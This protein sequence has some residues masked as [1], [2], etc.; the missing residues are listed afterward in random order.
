[1]GALYCNTGTL[2]QLMHA[3]KWVVRCLLLI[4]RGKACWAVVVLPNPCQAWQDAIILAARQMS[5]FTIPCTMPCTGWLLMQLDPTLLFACTIA[6]R[7]LTCQLCDMERS[8]CPAERSR[9]VGALCLVWQQQPVAMCAVHQVPA[10]SSSISSFVLDQS[11][12]QPYESPVKGVR[13][14]Q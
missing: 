2:R 10:K 3:G 14:R 7:H 4:A 1:M 9:Q 8:D 12:N 11:S 6:P 5:G 13:S